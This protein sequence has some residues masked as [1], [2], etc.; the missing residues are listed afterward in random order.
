MCFDHLCGKRF[1]LA[2]GTLRTLVLLFVTQTI[3]PFIFTDGR[4]SA[5][6]R[7]GAVVPA[8]IHIFPAF[9]YREEKL[10]FLLCGTVC[11]NRGDMRILSRTA[12]P[13]WFRAYRPLATGVLTENQRLVSV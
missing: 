1:E 5:F 7:L 11:V 9:E 10:N 4:I 2:I 13:Q 12:A 3:H 8:C 6:S